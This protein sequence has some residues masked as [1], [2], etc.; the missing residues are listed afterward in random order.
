MPA[1]CAFAPRCPSRQPPL[2]AID[3][4]R[5]HFVRCPVRAGAAP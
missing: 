5:E 4:A 3:A 2:V 1:G